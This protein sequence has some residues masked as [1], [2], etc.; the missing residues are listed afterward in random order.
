MRLN[1]V[2]SSGHIP[3]NNA[4]TENEG[5][6]RFIKLLFRLGYLPIA[7]SKPED[8]NSSEAK[9]KMSLWKSILIA[10]FDFF[11]FL[12]AIAYIPVWHIFNA[13]PSFDLSLILK[14]D[15]YVRVFEGTMTTVLTE[16]I[17][18]LYPLMC[19]WIYVAIGVFT[20]NSH[21]TKQLKQIIIT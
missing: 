10:L 8:S 1:V 13:G 14:T 19:W 21:L 12:I 7:W 17:F 11:I 3:G 2:H 9:F 15:Y 5:F 18:I 4:V 20:L 16:L 6:L